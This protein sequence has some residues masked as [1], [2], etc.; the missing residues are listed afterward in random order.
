M[1]LESHDLDFFTKTNYCKRTDR[2][3]V[4]LIKVKKLRWLIILE[5]KTGRNDLTRCFYG[6][7]EYMMMIH[8]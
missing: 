5:T 4:W 6:N 8:P 7:G 2:V 1:T 3:W